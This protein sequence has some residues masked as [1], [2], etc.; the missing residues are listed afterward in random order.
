MPNPPTPPYS[1]I[2]LLKKDCIYLVLNVSSCTALRIGSWMAGA[3]KEPE[4]GRGVESSVR[5]TG[6]QGGIGK[7]SSRLGSGVD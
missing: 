7:A 5:D 2:P 3:R 1:L 4:V 6:I